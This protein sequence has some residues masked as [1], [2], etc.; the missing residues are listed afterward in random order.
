MEPL[1]RFEDSS[2][3]SYTL[4]V[5]DSSIRLDCYRLGSLTGGI[6]TE[7]SH[8]IAEG[9]LLS[10]YGSFGVNGFEEFAA[11]A[12]LLDSTGWSTLHELV[13]KFQSDSF[14]WSETNW[15]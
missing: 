8:R 14:T 3:G 12:K 9:N 13:T 11:K 15:D 2:N 5:V 4:G 7:C 1:I 6:G 10:F